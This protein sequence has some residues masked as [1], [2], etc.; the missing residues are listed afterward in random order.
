VTVKVGMN[1]LLWSGDVTGPGYDAVFERLAELGY[2]GA[3]I[4]L[5]ALDPDVYVSLGDRL[6]KLGLSPLALTTR[7]RHANPIDADSATRANGVKES[8]LALE[9]ATALGAE[10]LC[11]PIVATPGV[12]TG[13]PGTSQERAWA[14][15]LLQTLGDAA[16]A[17]GVTLAIESLNRFQHYLMTTAAATADLCR[18]TDRSRCR[19]LYDTFHA[20]IEEKDVATAIAECADVLCYVHISENDRTTP[21]TG[22][23]AWASTFTALRAIGYDGWLTI[24]AFGQSDPVL[25]AQLKVWRRAYRTEDDIARDGIAFIRKSWAQA[26]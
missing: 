7:G 16:E 14:I 19:M 21:G 2:D 10:V 25:D 12:F 9:C 20:H 3:E 23:V 13:L 26:A 6:R 17:S 8:L 5:F 18:Q 4:P 24:E 15:E 11:G 22:Q 1:M